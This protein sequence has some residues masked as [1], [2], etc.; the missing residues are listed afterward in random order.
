M[1]F[2]GK[3]GLEWQGSLAMSMMQLPLL[4]FVGFHFISFVILLVAERLCSRVTVLMQ[5]TASL[6]SVG[7]A[8]LNFF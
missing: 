5:L 3:A 2:F 8:Q 1:S 6:N 4:N 7:L